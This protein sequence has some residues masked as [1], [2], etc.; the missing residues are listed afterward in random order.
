MIESFDDFCLWMYVMVDDM[1]Q[2]IEPLFK[3]PGPKPECSDSELLTMALVGECRKW[4]EETTQLSQW[5][6][7]RTLFPYIPTQS[8]YNRRRR[9]LQDAFN[10]LRQSV[11]KW[12]PNSCIIIASS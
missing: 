8:R 3:R 6:E 2:Q 12:R 10:I 1:W 11:L 7:H 4:H 9:A 5:Q